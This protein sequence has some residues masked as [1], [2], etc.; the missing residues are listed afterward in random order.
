MPDAAAKMPLAVD[1]GPKVRT[2]PWPPRRL[3]G[4]EEKQ[5]ADA[6]F[7]QSIATGEAFGYGGVQEEAYCHEFSASLGG[8]FADGVNSGTNAVY[9][10]LRSLELEPFTE[11]IV[12]PI[13]DPGGAMP[14]ALLNCIPVPSDAAVGSYNTGVDQVA[15]RLT[16]RTSAIIVAHIAGLPVDMDPI[17]ELAAKRNI[18]VVED[19]AQAHGAKYKGRPVGALGTVGA[20]STMFGKH[21]ASGGQ[22]GLVFTRSEQA[23]WRIRRCADRGKP[24]GLDGVTSNQFAALNCNM[25]ELHAAIG[26]VQLRKLPRIVAKRRAVAALLADACR[27][28]RTVR[29]MQELP[30]CEGS[31]WFA[32]LRLDLPALKV[33][34]AT[35]VKALAAEGIPAESEYLH[36]PA[37]AEWLRKRSVFGG[38]GYPWNCPLY[39][40]DATR[41]YDVPNAVATNACHFRIAIN[42]ACGP[43][44]VAD[45]AAAIAKVER[46]YAK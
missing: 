1:G 31:Y 27:G 5:A 18:P 32:F 29:M 34:K 3:F 15:A 37:L 4:Q 26:R 11:V 45:I 12:P 6:L 43:V 14:V 19:C 38:S 7:D 17:L 16:D 42:E 9:V 20:F 24:I 13:T 36:S 28:T 25:D 44:E 8:G 2:A 33:D 21:H 39:Q 30:L 46:A 41:Q 40:G 10:A 35:F 22:G 23:Y